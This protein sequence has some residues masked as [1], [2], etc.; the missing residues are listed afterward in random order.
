MR[1]SI[2]LIIYNK[3]GFLCVT[4]IFGGKKPYIS[5][6][7]QLLGFH[8]ADNIHVFYLTMFFALELTERIF[9][10][11]SVFEIKIEKNK[12]PPPIIPP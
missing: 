12:A 11:K 1:V 4:G 8:L 9:C 6:L 2:N 10:Q 3:L 5:L 7:Y